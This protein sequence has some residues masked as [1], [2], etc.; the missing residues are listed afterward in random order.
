VSGLVLNLA[1]A[2]QLAKAA[3]KNAAELYS[4]AAKEAVNPLVRRLFEQLTEFESYHYQKLVDLEH[5]LQE[6]GTF[7]EYENFDDETLVPAISEVKRIQGVKKTSAAKVLKQ[8]MAIEVEAEK[9]YTDLADQTS[10]PQ[11]RRMFLQ[12]AREERGHYLVIESA[13]YDVSNLKPLA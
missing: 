3:E 5:S 13:Y 6:K 8:A 11:G 10:D 7:I 4:K 1:S 12:L 9:R 2:I